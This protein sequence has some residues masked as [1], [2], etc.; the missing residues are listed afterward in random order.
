MRYLSLDVETTGL[1]PQQDQLLQVAMV[2]EDSDVDMPVEELSSINLLVLHPRY[3]GN[4][5]AL[6]LNG[7]ILRRISGQEPTDLQKIAIAD[8]PAMLLQFINLNFP[9]QRVTVA[10]K[11]AAGFDIPFMPFSVRER[12]R[13]RVIDPGSV[14]VDWSKDML[15]SLGDLTQDTVAHDALEDARDVIRVLRRSYSK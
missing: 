9:G 10:G 11:N 12:F 5:Y 3:V 14:F 7:S 8:L 2:V 13:H 15:P 4:A 6:G 1:D